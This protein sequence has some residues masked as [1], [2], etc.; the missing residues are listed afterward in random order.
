MFGPT[1]YLEWARRFYGKVRFDLATSGIPTVPTETLGQA[2]PTCLDDATGWTRLRDAIAAYNDVPADEAVAALGTT[3]A[4]WLAY[5]SLTKPGDEVLVESPAYEPLLRI[6]EG[7]GARVV[8]FERD[9]ATFAL[10]PERVARA[11]TARTRVVAVTNLHNPSGVRASDDAL[12][13]CARVAEQRSAWL[14]VDEVYAPFDGLVDE[15]GVFRRS[16]RRLAPNV[17]VAS[18]LTKCYGLGPHRIGWMLGRPDAIRLADDAITASCGMLPLPHAHLAL[19]AFSRLGEISTRARTLLGR[20]RQRVAE[21]AR[22]EGLGWSAPDAG[23]FGFASVPRAGD[24]TP[25]IEAA[26]SDRGVLVAAGSFFGVPSGFRLA[27]TAPPETL[28]EG[29]AALSALLRALPGRDG[30]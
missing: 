1:R 3:H 18:S 28:E 23:L 24:L 21:W 11:V 16:A 12:R 30:R 2:D 22:A 7:V 15:H 29:L 8:Q 6:A 25:A 19:H 17:V 9:P 27:W 4:L 5:A 10:D 26:A 20:K 14:L 13:A